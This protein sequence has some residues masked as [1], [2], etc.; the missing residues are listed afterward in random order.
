MI[1]IQ[2]EVYYPK[3]QGKQKEFHHE[4]PKLKTTKA[5][6]S[7]TT[8]RIRELIKK[9]IFFFYFQKRQTC[10]VGISHSYLESQC[11]G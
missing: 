3:T 10:G 2:R 8:H 11:A 1:T 7:P 6:K 5:E 4:V 9:Y